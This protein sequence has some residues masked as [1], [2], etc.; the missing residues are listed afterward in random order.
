MK[1]LRSYVRRKFSAVWYEARLIGLERNHGAR[2]V[3]LVYLDGSRH[4]W[5]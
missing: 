2:Q 3:T 4:S 1:I 5:S